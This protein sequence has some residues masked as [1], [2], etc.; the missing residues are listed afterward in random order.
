MRMTPVLAAG[1]IAA[2][3]VVSQ[4]DAEDAQPAADREA[5]LRQGIELHDAG[6][7]K[8]AIETYQKILDSNPRD[9]T[10]LYEI[11]NS[12]LS[13]GD[14]KTCETFARRSLDIQPTAYGYSLA[15]S[16]QEET[17]DVPGALATFA[18]SIELYPGD[19][20]LNFNYA[21]TLARQN[22]GAEAKQHLR[23]A[24][25]AEPRYSSPYLTY[26]GV[27]SGE[28]NEVA[29][30]YMWLRFLML[31]PG[32]Q[33]SREVAHYVTDTLTPPPVANSNGK[34]ITIHPPPQRAPSDEFPTDPMYYAVIQQLLA[35]AG[36]KAGP[37]S[38]KETPAE[39]LVSHGL[40]MLAMMEERSNTDD[41]RDRQT[42][43]WQNAV[44]PLMSLKDGDVRTPFLYYV[45][46]LSRVD[47]AGAW[48]DAH[49]KEF[50]AL[51]Q[52][53]SKRD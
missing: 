5:L 48:L 21:V 35:A 16:C 49:P 31:E 41:S 15:A 1:L 6:S 37:K 7:Y 50:D 9:A 33:R 13:L 51:K 27:L 47:G 26:A 3:G 29:A 2:A 38:D 36:A 44:V 17:G 28:Q 12:Y 43:V 53:L 22:R 4:A 52:R 8:S 19:V 34:Q 30:L 11:G 18:K 46:A 42:F 24:I 14:F 23:T 32:S 40:L 20:M 45:A 10:A 39:R 25:K